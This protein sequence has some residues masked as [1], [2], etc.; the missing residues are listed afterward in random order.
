MRTAETRKAVQV[1]E[2]TKSDLSFNASQF[3]EWLPLTH[4]FNGYLMNRLA[5]RLVYLN[6]NKAKKY[7]QKL[8]F[9]R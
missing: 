6:Q 3:H 5:K 4:S 1:F 9:A 7:I 8:K 2:Y